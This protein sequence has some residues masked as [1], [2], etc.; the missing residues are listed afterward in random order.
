MERGSNASING[1]LAMVMME[2]GKDEKA[3]LQWWLSVLWQQGG[4]DRGTRDYGRA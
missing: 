3:R 2:L 1:F 4:V